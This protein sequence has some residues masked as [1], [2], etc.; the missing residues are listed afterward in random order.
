MLQLANIARWLRGPVRNSDPAG[1]IVPV[2]KSNTLDVWGDTYAADSSRPCRGLLVGTAG[3]ATV[4]DASGATRTA[5]PLQAGYNPI[6]VKQVLNAGTA[7]DI[8][9]LE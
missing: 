6:R 7:A 2:T 5:I 4:I 8:W 3:T 1:L 9:A